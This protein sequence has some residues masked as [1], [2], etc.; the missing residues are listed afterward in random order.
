MAGFAITPQAGEKYSLKI[1]EPAGIKTTYDLPEAKADGVAIFTAKNVYGEKV[2]LALASPKAKDVTITLS[3]REK[4]LAKQEVKLAAGK[5]SKIELAAGDADGVLIATVRDAEGK[6]LA[7]RLVFRSP[8]KQVSVK[9]AANEEQYVPGGKAKLT[10]TTT[11]A[12]GKPVSSVVGV[13]VTD[14]SVLEM[15]DKRE[16]APRLPVMVFLEND[17]QELADAHVYLDSANEQAP[18]AVDLLLGTQGWRRFAFIDT[19]KFAADHGDAARRVLACR[20]Q[21]IREESEGKLK[22]LADR[23][24]WI[25][26]PRR[27]LRGRPPPMAAV[28]RSRAADAPP[29]DWPPSKEAAVATSGKPTLEGRAGEPE[30]RQRARAIARRSGSRTCG[31]TPS[32]WRTAIVKCEKRNGFRKTSS[33]SA[34]TPTPCGPTASRATAKISPKRSTGAPA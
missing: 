18:Q 19:T 33:P 10:F 13:T 25:P 3:K 4:E 28:C 30:A 24:R 27:R 31:R 23:T 7:E 21:T 20:S 29:T 8:A 6:P 16:Q 34:S 9:V 26:L 1:T 22:E 15:I 11:D 32:S 17:V 12:T 2:E 5:P 14:D